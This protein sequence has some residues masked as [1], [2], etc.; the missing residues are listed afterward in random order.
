MTTL[1]LVHGWGFDARIWDA[2]AARLDGIGHAA[3]DLGFR[4]PPR[5]P[6]VVRPV[7]VGHSMGFAWALANVARPWAGAVAVNAFPRFTRTDDFPDGVPP[8]RLAR[9]RAQFAVDPAGTTAGFLAQCGMAEPAIDDIRPAPLGEALA[10]LETC[11]QRAALAALDCPVLAL[12]GGADPL[13]TPAMA[14]SGFS[15]GALDILPAGGHLLPITHPDWLAARIR[16]FAARW[17]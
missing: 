15:E 2:V 11:D 13:V 4:G 9:M 1:L 5:I 10:W 17:T 14:R 8:H 6:E 7:V 12:A 16:A 3:M